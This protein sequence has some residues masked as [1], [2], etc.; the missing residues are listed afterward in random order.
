MNQFKAEAQKWKSKW[1]NLEYDN[2]FLEKQIIT[3]RRHNKWLK[4]AL[5]K[6]QSHCQLLID[7]VK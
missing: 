4:I 7:E 1:E 2:T 3:W 5:G 6:S